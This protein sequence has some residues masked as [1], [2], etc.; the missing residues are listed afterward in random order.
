APTLVLVLAYRT[1]AAERQRHERLDSL[2]RAVQALHGSADEAARVGVLLDEARAVFRVEVAEVTLLRD[3]G[4]EADRWQS[5]ARRRAPRL[6][7][8]LP[9]R[10]ARRALAAG[11][12]AAPRRPRGGAGRGARL[13]R[14]AAGR[15]ARGRP[16]RRLAGRGRPRRR[17]RPVRAGRRRAA[18]DARRP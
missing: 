15:P 14:G 10:A 13:A 2:H 5:T 6:R 11:R 18:R 3:G 8:R 7:A 1:T 12:L 9:R 4:R 16:A 17:R